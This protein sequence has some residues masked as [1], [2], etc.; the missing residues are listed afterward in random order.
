MAWQASQ[1]FGGQLA[2]RD[3]QLRWR[4]QYRRALHWTADLHPQ[5]GG[6]RDR[7]RPVVPVRGRHRR[8]AIPSVSAG[9]RQQRR[10]R[11]RQ[12]G[13]APGDAEGRGGRRYWLHQLRLVQWHAVP[14]GAPVQGGPGSGWP[15][16][17]EC[18]LRP[19][20]SVFFTATD[21]TQGVSQTARVDGVR[22]VDTSAVGATTVVLSTVP[23]ASAMP[24]RATRREDEGRW[25]PQRD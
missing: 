12:P 22:V 18:L 2:G 3:Q 13:R 11:A 10:G 7:R 21:I 9:Q 1:V 15:A 14:H 25:R 8:G 17:A 23:A 16:P 20:G 4:G 5:P 19:D 24:G 6:L